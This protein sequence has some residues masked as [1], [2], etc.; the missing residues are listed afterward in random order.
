MR[1]IQPSLRDLG[2]TNLLPP[3]LKRRALSNVPPGQSGRCPERTLSDLVNQA[4]GLTPA[5]AELTWKT[6]PLR[7]TIL[8]PR[9]PLRSPLSAK[10]LVSRLRRPT[11]PLPMPSVAAPDT[12]RRL[13]LNLRCVSG[14]ATEG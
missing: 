5:E 14:E 12:H 6:A 2:S 10:R 7:M 1:P 4:Y 11:Q 9:W 8:A 3:A 13:K